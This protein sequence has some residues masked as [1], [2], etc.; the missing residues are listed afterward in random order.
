MP[1]CNNFLIC[2]RERNRVLRF[3][4][5]NPA[6]PMASVPNELP[7]FSARAD[8]LRP[9]RALVFAAALTTFLVWAWWPFLRGT[10][11]AWRHSPSFVLLPVVI[12]LSLAL[13]RSG[14]CRS[15][16]AA[17]QLDGLG[18]LL[19]VIAAILRFTG[20]AL[21][22]EFAEGATW[23]LSLVGI[24]V[25]CGGRANLQWLAPP[26]LLLGFL[27]PIP[28]A[29]AHAVAEPLQR[30]VSSMAAYLTQTYGFP[31]VPSGSLILAG[32]ASVDV[33]RHCVGLGSLLPFVA[34]ATG[35][36][37][38]IDRPWWQRVLL[39]VSSLPI[40]IGS[41][42]VVLSVHCVLA[43][44]DSLLLD[45]V[46]RQGPALALLLAVL[47]Y[48]FEFVYFSRLVVEPDAVPVGRGSRLK[49]AMPVVVRDDQ[50]AASGAGDKP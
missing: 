3:H 9:E 20:E 21:A 18:T 48:A 25:L 31:A 23:L 44:G 19:I 30:V 8:A 43:G 29:I 49:T 32:S 40:G 38:L 35:L 41:L 45:V 16:R 36:A 5:L 22:V 13:A 34:A 15:G 12:I 46:H 7:A 39:V 17:L 24:A 27:L 37:L 42:A 11:V 10:A 1:G 4:L 2:R 47:L 50:T 28:T 14:Y 26:I 6:V 33:T